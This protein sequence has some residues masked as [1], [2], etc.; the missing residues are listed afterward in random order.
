M[1]FI[2]T[3]PAGATAAQHV[4]L[5]IDGGDGELVQEDLYGMTRFRR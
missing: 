1:N 2:G 5:E 3:P 4:P